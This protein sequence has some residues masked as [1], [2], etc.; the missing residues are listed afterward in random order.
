MG[1]RLQRLIYVHDG[2]PGALGAA[3]EANGRVLQFMPEGSGLF[4]MPLETGANSR[5]ISVRVDT[6]P[7]AG[8]PPELLPLVGDDIPCIVGVAS[9]EARV[10]VSS[11]ALKRSNPT[12]SD[13]RG[14]VRYGLARAG[15]E[16]E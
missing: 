12:V 2:E 16:L 7:A 6:R 1:A 11:T 15:W 13:L 10:L 3:I 8:L 14:K 9:G 4:G 5:S